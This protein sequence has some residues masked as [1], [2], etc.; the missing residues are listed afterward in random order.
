MSQKERFAA[1]ERKEI[2][3]SI[4]VITC[5]AIAACVRIITAL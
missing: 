2:I 3:V 1:E 4:I 5:I